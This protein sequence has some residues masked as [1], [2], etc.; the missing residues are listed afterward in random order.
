MLVAGI[1]SRKYQRAR[2][3]QRQS[4][5]PTSNRSGFRNSPRVPV[6]LPRWWNRQTRHVESVVPPG[7]NPGWGTRF[8]F[9]A[10]SADALCS[11]RRCSELLRVAQ[12]FAL[13]RTSL[14]LSCGAQAR[15]VESEGRHHLREADGNWPTC[16]AQTLALPGSS[17]G[18][19][20]ISPCWL[21]QTGTATSLR[22]SAFVGSNPTRGTKI[23]L[24]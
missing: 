17:P 10:Q 21:M 20:T 24:R 4:G 5:C 8:A 19:R 13:L 12:S 15:L 2:V 6:I 3:A 23:A 9:L 22:S 18:L 1:R 14:R 16:Q 7:S 11:E